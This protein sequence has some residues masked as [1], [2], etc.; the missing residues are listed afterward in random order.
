I[1]PSLPRV[2]ADEDAAEQAIENLLANAIK[3]S[4]DSKTISIDVR[5]SKTHVTVRVT[6]Q[7]IGVPR[8]EQGRIFRKF[9]RVQRDLGGGQ[10]GCGLGLAIVDRTM[11][12]HN[13]FVG[14]ASERGHGSTLTLDL[15]L[16]AG[17]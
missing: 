5:R 4:G 1:E 9:Y 12:G 3:Y 10:Q 17:A 16:S 7:G 11:R 2:L 14:G 6:E 13:G 15:P 8:R